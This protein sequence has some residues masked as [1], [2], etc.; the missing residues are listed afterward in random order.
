L[1]RSAL[2]NV[3]V[4]C[5]DL[6]PSQVFENSVLYND[7]IRAM[8]DDSFFAIGAK[9]RGAGLV[10]ELGFHRGKGQGPFDP[11]AVARLNDCLGHVRR[12]LVIRARLK[13]AE[14]REQAAAG[15]LDAIGYAVFTLS[16]AG[17][18]LHHNLAAE[19]LLRAATAFRVSGGRLCATAAGDRSRLAEAIEAVATSAS[20]RPVALAVA[21]GG[22]SPYEV[23]ILSM[24]TTLGR[25]VLVVVR[26]PSLRDPSLIDRLRARHGLTLAE[27]EIATRLSEGASTAELSDERRT[28]HETV[29]SQIKAIAAKMGCRRQSE[30]VA[31][32]RSLPLFAPT[33]GRA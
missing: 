32:V 20:P 14:A 12:A 23:S 5:A 22:R 33:D 13:Q 31:A 26:D 3:A 28:A 24:P 15:G 16:A 7:W 1:Q 29:R 30:I 11:E 2:V 9:L 6:V 21:C 19:T 4:D 17:R 27:A 10:A 25:N 18:L 8:G